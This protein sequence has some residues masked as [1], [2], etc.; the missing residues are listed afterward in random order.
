MANHD[1]NEPPGTQ[2]AEP[3]SPCAPKTG[4]DPGAQPKPVLATGVGSFA[5]H[6]DLFLV[7]QWGVLHD[8]RA[9]YPGVEDCLRRLLSVGKR[10]VILSNSGKR[11][12]DNA[13][14]LASMGIAPDCYTAL[15]TSGEI[16][17]ES[18]SARTHPFLPSMGHRCLLL[19]S[20]GESSLVEGLDIELVAT[21][22]AADF[23]LLAGTRDDR[24]MTFYQQIL[25]YAGARQIPLICANPDLVRLSPQGLVFS[26]GEVAHRYERMGGP[27]HYIGKPYPMIYEYCRKLLPGFEASRITAVGDSFFHDVVGGAR[28]GLATAL[29]TDGIHKAEFPSTLDDVG[30]L[31]KLAEMARDY[32]AW[33][34]WVIRQ[35]QW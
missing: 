33:P 25:E 11:A 3:C 34:D 5:D 22:V 14:R 20:E 21:V 19:S 7:D 9:A 2:K 18:L 29:V 1:L 31:R 8:G 10:V 12:E 26:A 30:R 24:P 6:Y 16:A 32:G 13:T 4:P 17:R 28:F 35:F 15:I 27:V 23:I